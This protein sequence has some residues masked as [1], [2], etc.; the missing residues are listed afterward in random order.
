MAKRRT[1]PDPV[2]CAH[3]GTWT[4][5]AWVDTRAPLEN[6]VPLCTGCVNGAVAMTEAGYADGPLLQPSQVLH[7]VAPEDR[8]S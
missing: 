5:Y 6:I 1:K 2:R 7:V 3:C 4:V 8:D